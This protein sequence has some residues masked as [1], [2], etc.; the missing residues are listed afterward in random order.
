M[1]SL[2]LPGFTRL[3]PLLEANQTLA[4]L[5]DLL[6]AQWGTVNRNDAD[7]VERDFIHILRLM[8]PA[9]TLKHLKSSVKGRHLLSPLEV[10]EATYRDWKAHLVT[11]EKPKLLPPEVSWLT[12][13]DSSQVNL[14]EGA[15]RVASDLGHQA[16]I[17][18]EVWINL[19]RRRNSQLGE[20][21]G[22][23]WQKGD[24]KRLPRLSFHMDQT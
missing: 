21:G 14:P 2:I 13:F 10:L 17:H 24:G 6:S 16:I 15:S 23:R 11:F 8:G 18:C 7:T 12:K 4:E 9:A 3:A 22:W 19:V 20:E 1:E 5:A